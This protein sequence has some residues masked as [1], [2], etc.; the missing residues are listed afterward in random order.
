MTRT[1]YADT[2]VAVWRSQEQIRN[3]LSKLN[4]VGVRS[5]FFS[6]VGLFLFL[7]FFLASPASSV[8]TESIFDV[9]E[10]SEGIADF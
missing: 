9:F 10:Y 6:G 5:T 1:A 2:N 8:E 4:V 7:Y 3:L